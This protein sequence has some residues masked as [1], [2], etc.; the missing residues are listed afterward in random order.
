MSKEQTA[1]VT[2]PVQPVMEF[3]EVKCSKDFFNEFILEL[4]RLPYSQVAGIM[5]QIKTNFFAIPLA[6]AVVQPPAAVV[7]KK[8]T[9]K[10]NKAKK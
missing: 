10:T 4:Q 9:A 3:N 6:P 8:K 2:P 5:E 7:E 1:P